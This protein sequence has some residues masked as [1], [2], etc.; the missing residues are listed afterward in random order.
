MLF[1]NRE[2]RRDRP[3]A[4]EVKRYTIDEK[5]EMIKRMLPPESC[6]PGKLSEETGI[7]KS[8]LATWKAKALKGEASR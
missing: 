5:E 8:T 4:R 2:K 6:T 1:S 3:M 7:S